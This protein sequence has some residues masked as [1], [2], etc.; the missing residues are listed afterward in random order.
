MNRKREGRRVGKRV[1]WE[2][3]GLRERSGDHMK[4]GRRKVGG[5]Q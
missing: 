4:Q 1:I 3:E 5:G 2:N